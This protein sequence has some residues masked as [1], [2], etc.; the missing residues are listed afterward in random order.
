MPASAISSGASLQ[1]ALV[2]AL[3]GDATL[4]TALKGAKIYDAPPP[5]AA[6]PYV[7]V[8]QSTERD[9]STG[10]EEGSEHIVT[11]FVWSNARGRGEA[12]DLVEHLRRVLHDASPVLEG[13]HLVSLR[14]EF[15]EV[16]RDGDGETWRG[17]VRLRAV[18]EPV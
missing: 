14:H 6:R 7:T 2:S 13:W 15:S 9:W 11:L 16:R 8:G 10:S 12:H 1:A 3:A 17:L 4:V 18:T 5:G